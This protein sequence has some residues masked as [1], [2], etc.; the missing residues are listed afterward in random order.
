MPARRET[1][2]AHSSQ[3]S[4]G[5]RGRGRRTEEQLIQIATELFCS[6]G[7]NGTSIAE[8]AKSIGVT[9][10]SVYYYFPSKQ[11]L[12]LRVLQSGL[13]GFLSRLEEIVEL[14]VSPREKLRLAIKNHLDFVFRR[15]DAISVFLRERRFLESPYSEDYQRNVDRYDELFVAIIRDG[16]PVG[17]FPSV[18]ARITSLIILG[19]LNWMIEWHQQDGRLGQEDLSELTL[20]LIL[21]RMLA[22]PR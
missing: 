5:P 3:V 4:P 18:D 2:P 7:Y 12:L 21:D 15:R 6:G 16:I 19:A 20:E 13:D 11:Q 9:N 17:D 10:A 14:E 1:K 8:L 22:A